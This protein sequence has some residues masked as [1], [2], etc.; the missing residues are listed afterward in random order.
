MKIQLVLHN[1]YLFIIKNA[2]KG[3]RTKN[4][5]SIFQL[6]KLITQIVLAIDGKNSM[7]DLV[8]S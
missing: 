2:G 7:H 5:I 8:W 6:K 1:L 3:K 4:H